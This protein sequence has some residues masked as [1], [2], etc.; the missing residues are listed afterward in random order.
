VSRTVY[1]ENYDRFGEFVAYHLPEGT[2]DVITREDS[3]RLSLKKTFGWCAREGEHVAGVFATPDGP[4]IFLDGQHLVG[5]YGATS[6]KVEPTADHRILEYTLT[7][8]GSVRFSLRYKERFG[9]GTNPYDN[10]PEDIDLFALIAAGLR[11]EAFFR[12]YTKAWQ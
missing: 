11:N 12:G 10:E 7:H 1:L 6:A 4:V 3:P 5:R 9:I 2:F 8:E